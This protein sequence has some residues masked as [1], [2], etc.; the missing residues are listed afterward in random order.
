MAITFNG[1][2]T[3]LR[4]P[5]TYVEFDNSKASQ[6]PS[7][8]PWS[9]LLMGQKLAAGSEPELTIKTVTSEA[10]A[11]TLYG[12]GSMIHRMVKFYLANNRITEL[13]V[14]AIDDAAAGVQ[15]TGKIAIDAGTATADGTLQ[16]YIAG[17][18]VS[19]AV[20]DGDDQDAVAAALVAA[21]TAA[22]DLPVTAAVNGGNANECDLTAK[23]KGVLGNELDLRVNYFD[24]DAYPAGI[25]ETITPMASGATNPDIADIIGALPD[26]QYNLMIN[27]WLDSANLLLLE[28]ELADRDGPTRQIDSR[29]ISYKLDSLSNLQAIGNARNSRYGSIS[30]PAKSG[31]TAPYEYAAA[32]TAQVALSAQQDPARPMQTLPLNGVLAPAESERFLLSE[33]NILLSD[34]IATDKVDSGGVVRIERVIS[35]YQTNAA[36]SPDTSYLDF[37][38]GLTLSFLRYDFRVQMSSKFPRHKLANDGTRFAPGQAVMTPLVGKAEAVR[39]FADWELLGYVEGL[40]QFKTDLIVERNLQDPN[41]LDFLL[42]PDLINQLRVIGTQIQFL[43]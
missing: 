11:I 43:L 13:K 7:V 31:P 3:S 35:T 18:R 6:G 10:Q 33:R 20:S 15:A 37:N 8:M 2:P 41:R 17:Q 22:G 9:V 42:G 1:I 24:D 12:Q 34:G 27:P 40:E 36:G 5:F 32:K 4:V 19:V 21:I 28:A 26:E 30:G 16:V 23:H 39:I 25:T 29:F 38:T 14:I